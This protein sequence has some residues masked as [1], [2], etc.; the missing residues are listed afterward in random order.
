MGLLDNIRGFFSDSKNTQ[1]T[2]HQINEEDEKSKLADKIVD[3]INK[4][5]RINSFDNSIWNLSNISSYDLKKRS[6]YELQEI[7]S[8]LENRLVELERQSQR[9][10]PKTEALYV[11]KWTGQKPEH[12]SDHDFERFQKD[13]SR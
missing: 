3:S 1:T 11:S 4:I 2:Q 9:I 5:K 13:E 7:N 6:L 8:R 12:M 10:D